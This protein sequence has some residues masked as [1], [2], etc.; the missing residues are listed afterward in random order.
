MDDPNP[1]S[2]LAILSL[3]GPPVEL[4]LIAL[5]VVVAPRSLVLRR[6]SIAS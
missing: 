3:I 1:I 5:R 4:C 2:S 6:D